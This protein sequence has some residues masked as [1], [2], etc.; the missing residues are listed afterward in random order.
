MDRYPQ[1]IR[2]FIAS[3]GS[4]ANLAL[5]HVTSKDVLAYRDSITKTGKT[6]RTANLSV[7][8]VSAAFNAAVRE[9]IIE[10]NPATALESLPVNSEEKGTFTPEQVAKLVGAA[11]GDWRG[12]ILLGYYTGAR[13]GD[14][15][16]MRWSAVDWN[17][18]IIRLTPS[19]LRN[20]S[21]FHCIHNSNA[22][23]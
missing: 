19:K 16:N 20:R 1:V 21:Q 4:R 11:D 17:K 3:L 10:S 12:A 5:S 8:V 23:F 13:L 18:K 7:K 2:D 6:T 15:A 14:V 9:N 22:S